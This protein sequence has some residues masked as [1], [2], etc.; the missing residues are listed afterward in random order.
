ARYQLDGVRLAGSSVLAGAVKV[1]VHPG[2]DVEGIDLDCSRV[3]K[4]Q[5]GQRVDHR[6]GLGG[7][8]RIKVGAGF[9]VHKIKAGTDAGDPMQAARLQQTLVHHVLEVKLDRVVG[10]E[11]AVGRDAAVLEGL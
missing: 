11:V 6:E 1:L 2:T 10:I 3:G 7:L 9:L 8:W 4:T 5:P